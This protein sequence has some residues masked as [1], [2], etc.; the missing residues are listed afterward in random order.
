VPLPDGFCQQA[1]EWAREHPAF[2]SFRRVRYLR[3]EASVAFRAAM[4]RSGGWAVPQAGDWSREIDVVGAGCGMSFC[5]RRELYH[6]VGE[7]EEMPGW[8]YEDLLYS[9]RVRKA[10]GLTTMPAALPVEIVHLW[11]KEEGQASEEVK[12]LYAKRRA[13]I[14]GQPVHCAGSMKR[15]RAIRH[16]E[17]RRKKGKA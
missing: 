15:D 10:L 2:Q 6:R 1:L 8:G 13:E 9:V 3:P 16:W 17:E 11:H 5:I 12:A 4:G 7:W 14:E